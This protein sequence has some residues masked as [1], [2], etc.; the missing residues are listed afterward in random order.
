MVDDE[1]YIYINIC[2]I[3]L[4]R[5]YNN[6]GNFAP[7]PVKV[8]I[9]SET[10][11]ARGGGD[12]VVAAPRLLPY[13]S[14]RVPALSSQWNTQRDDIWGGGRGVTIMF[15]CRNCYTVD[16]ASLGGRSSWAREGMSAL[17]PAEALL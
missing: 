10:I 15:A 9:Q 13:D 3:N 6:A 8:K 5:F 16:N 2:Q 11:P 4:Y 14:T 17:T 7:P 12:R 1:L